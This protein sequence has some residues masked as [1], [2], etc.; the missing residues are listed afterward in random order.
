[1]KPSLYSSLLFLSFLIFPADPGRAGGENDETLID[2]TGE[3]ISLSGEIYKSVSIHV[4]NEEGRGG[5]PTL[6]GNG[7]GG[8]G[9]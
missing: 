7:G 6:M 5:P 9:N 2:E 3:E 4:S 8:N 1:M